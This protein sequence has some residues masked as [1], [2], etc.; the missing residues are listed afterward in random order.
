MRRAGALEAELTKLDPADVTATA[1]TG[2]KPKP[3]IEPPRSFDET[4]PDTSSARNR[5]LRVA[6]VSSRREAEYSQSA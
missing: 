3:L 2:Q 1:D 6:E 4:V 5:A